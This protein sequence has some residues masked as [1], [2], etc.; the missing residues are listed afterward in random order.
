[1]NAPV[2]QKL[3]SAQYPLDKSL[4]SRQVFGRI[5]LSIE[6]RF[7][8]W[9]AL[10]TFWITKVRTTEQFRMPINIFLCLAFDVCHK[11]G[12]ILCDFCS[13]NSKLYLYVAQTWVVHLHR[14]F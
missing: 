14:N 5:A 2:V 8:H 1:M 10:S 11:Q 7:I 4:S 13:S 12:L 9:I 3:D 6:Q